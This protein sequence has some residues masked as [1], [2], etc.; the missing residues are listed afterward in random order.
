MIGLALAA[1]VGADALGASLPELGDPTIISTGTWAILLVVTFG[2]LLSFTPLQSMEEVGAS[3]VG[4]FALYLLLTSIGAK[5]DLAAVLDV[6]L[7]LLA[8][9]LWIVIHIAFL[10]M[11]ARLACAPLFFVATGSM[12]NVGPPRVPRSLQVFIYRL[13][14]PSAC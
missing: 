6:P 11:A 5:A 2:L 7:Y 9:V 8:G 4:Y 1:T 14:P 13:W 12:A 3:R 10:L